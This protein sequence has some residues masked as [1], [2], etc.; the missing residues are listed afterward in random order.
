MARRKRRKHGPDLSQRSVFLGSSDFEVHGGEY[1]YAN[2]N[3]VVTKHYQ[4]NLLVINFNGSPQLTV[5]ASMATTV[6]L[7]GYPDHN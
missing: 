5:T 3:A 1:V 2:G 7:F 4:V 6:G